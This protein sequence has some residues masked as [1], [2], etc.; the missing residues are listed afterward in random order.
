MKIDSHQHFWTYNKENYGWINDDMQVIKRDFYPEDLEPLLKS[1]GFDACVAVQA[2]QSLEENDFL[3]SLAD[4]HDFIKVVVGWVDLKAEN[5]D[6]VLSRYAQHSKFKG[7]RHI[8][9]DEP[10]VDFMLNSNFYRGV[11]KLA[12]YQL[13]YDLLLRPEHLPN[14]IKFVADFPE[15]VFILDHISK[16]LI[17]KAELSPWREDIQKLASFPNVYC[18]LSGMVTEAN[19]ATWEPEDF[20]PYLDVV[21]EAFG[22][23]RLMLGSDWP[24]CKLAGEYQE[25]MQLTINYVSKLSE[26][27]QNAIFSENACRAYC[28]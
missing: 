25:V 3:L 1:S 27:E 16:P 23:E 11:G 18:K 15:Q 26:S 9:H 17:A 5:C 10:D 14:A 20:E 2:R 24:V 13:S 28:I 4:E 19:L 12:K 6:E 21:L 8:I 22:P 7:I